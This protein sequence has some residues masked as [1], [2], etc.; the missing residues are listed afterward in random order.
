MNI[1]A[2][3]AYNVFRRSAVLMGTEGTVHKLHHAPNRGVVVKNIGGVQWLRKN[4]FQ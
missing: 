1:D 2:R 3:V 4:D